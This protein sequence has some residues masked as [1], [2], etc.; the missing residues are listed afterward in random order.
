MTVTLKEVRK[1]GIAVSRGIAIGKLYLFSQNTEVVTE[2]SLLKEELDAEV[3]R[4]FSALKQAADQIR[5]LQKKLENDQVFE[6]AAILDAHLEMLQDP[7]LT[8]EVEKLIRDQKLNAESIFSRI[9]KGAK[10]RFQSMSDPFFQDRFKDIQDL[11]HRILSFLRDHSSIGIH[12]MPEGSIFVSKE[13]SAA[14]VAEASSSKVAAFIT[15]VGGVTS[16]AAIVAKAKGIP[17]VTGISIDELESD[18]I[19]VVDGRSAEVIFSPNEETLK[20][21]RD[22][23]KRLSDHLKCL[24]R[25]NDLPAETFDGCRIALKGNVDSLEEVSTCFQMGGEGIGLLRTEYLFLHRDS[26]PA[27]DEQ[28]EIY[29]K[30]VVA[31]KDKGVVIR[32]F[33]FSQDKFPHPRIAHEM[34]PYIGMRSLSQILSQKSLFRN[35]IV[36]ILQASR[37]GSLSLLFPM[38]ASLSELKQAKAIVAEVKKELK[39][40][41]K[42][43]VGC[44]IEVPS[45]AII[46]DLLAKECDFLSIGTNDLVQY[47]LAADRRDGK[48]CVPFDPSILRL[49]QKISQ[50]GAKEGI[51]VTVCGEMAQDPRFTPV[52]IGL[53]VSEL[54]MAP[55]MIPVVKNG[56]RSLCLVDTID[57]A[58]KVLEMTS[59]EEVEALLQKEY[60]KNVP[61]DCLYT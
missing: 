30:F 40:K 1:K 12:E 42:I 56:V 26:F 46:A 15:E 32:T 27:I 8:L 5:N 33:D 51:P 55:R 50:E 19:V 58:K 60:Q 21:Y 17:F 24:D 43:P 52:L 29:K 25:L 54:S 31:T 2:Y 23:G 36:A 47:A 16:H 39:I 28:F 11:S 18:Q 48:T 57:F 14:V 61:D 41:A 10:A 13:L 6:G 59:A 44:M 49:I 53:G 37:F 38:V 20:F 3:K 34:N 35:Q 45:A 22:E 4:Y 9:V 7:L